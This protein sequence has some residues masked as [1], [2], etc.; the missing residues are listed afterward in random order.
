MEQIL[1]KAAG[2]TQQ[3]CEVMAIGANDANAKTVLYQ[4][5]LQVLMQAQAVPEAGSL[6]TM[7]RGVQ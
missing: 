5:V 6:L 1:L 7:P 2:V 4:I 3:I